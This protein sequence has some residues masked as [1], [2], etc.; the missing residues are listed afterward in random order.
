MRSQKPQQ[1]WDLPYQHFLLSDTERASMLARGFLKG[2]ISLPGFFRDQRRELP[3]LEP[4][5]ASSWIATLAF[6]DL[7]IALNVIL[8]NSEFLTQP[9]LSEIERQ[10]HS[11]EINRA[12][13][14]MN[15]AASSLVEYSKKSD[16][17]RLPVQHFI[18]RQ[19]R[20]RFG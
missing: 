19:L 17:T 15:E 7:R 1:E 12:V 6:H 18:H 10:V 20:S 8:A 11:R 5:P 16:M 14:R 3:I 2:R 9:R 4:L 13:D